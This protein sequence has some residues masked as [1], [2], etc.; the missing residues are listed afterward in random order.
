MS[1][2]SCCGGGMSSAARRCW[3]PPP[4]FTPS[5]IRPSSAPPPPR[6]SCRSTPWSGRRRSAPSALTRRGVMQKCGSAV[7]DVYKSAFIQKLLICSMHISFVL[8]P[9]SAGVKGECGECLIDLQSRIR[10]PFQGNP[11]SSENHRCLRSGY[12]IHRNTVR[13]HPW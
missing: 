4:S 1:R 5:I 10:I 6:G 13:Q 11:V 2:S 9:P 8:Q 3:P 7:H 12:H